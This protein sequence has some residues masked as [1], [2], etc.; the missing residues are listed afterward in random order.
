MTVRALAIVDALSKEYGEVEASFR[1]LGEHI[2]AIALD[3]GEEVRSALKDV[4][5]AA[6]Q[7]DLG[8]S[9]EMLEWI[10]SH[11]PERLRA[12]LEEL[13]RRLIPR[14]PAAVRS[15]APAT[16]RDAADLAD[17]FTRLLHIL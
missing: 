11:Y 17:R 2:G 8:R 14:P 13:L 6:V 12:V 16:A 10:E 1:R 3:L 5:E 4:V 7:E 9:V 15:I